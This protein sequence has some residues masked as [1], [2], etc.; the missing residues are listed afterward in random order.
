[1]RTFP[2]HD[3]M[4][5]NGA[6]MPCPA[7]NDLANPRL[8]AFWIGDRQS[9]E[10]THV[11]LTHSTVK[12]EA[13]KTIRFLTS[14]PNEPGYHGP[15]Y[16]GHLR[17]VRT[18]GYRRGCGNDEKS[19]GTAVTV[20]ARILALATMGF[21]IGLQSIPEAAAGSV[22][23]EVCVGFASTAALGYGNNYPVGWIVSGGISSIRLGA[24]GEVGAGY[25]PSSGPNLQAN[26]YDFMGGAR[27]ATASQTERVRAFAQVLVGGIRAGNNYAH[28]TAFAW[29][30][31]GGFDLA[32]SHFAAVRFQGD[33]RLIQPGGGTLKQFRASAGLVLHASS[34]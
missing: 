27:M 14:R 34:R 20:R 30:P 19:E 11:P 9:V 29:Q 1:M 23:T 28:A 21:L 16:A 4:R 26:I 8:T 24:I 10:P 18:Q 13:T 15:L 25:D 31:G 5:C 7:C 33:L 2:P 17:R 3:D 6:A 22:A 12:G 32:V